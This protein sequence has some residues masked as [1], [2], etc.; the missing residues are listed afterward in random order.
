MRTPIRLRLQELEDRRTPTFGLGWGVPMA[1]AGSQSTNAVTTDL[2]NNSYVT[3]Y[4]N[5]TVDFDPG[6]GLA[7]FT[8]VVS[9]D[10]FV[11]KYSPTGTPVWV[12]TMGGAGSEGAFAVKLDSQNRVHLVGDFSGTADFDPGPATFALSSFGGS[13]DGF[14]ATLDNDGNFVWAGQL[15]GTGDDRA[16]GVG[17]DAADN[18]Y[19]VGSFSGTADLD[20]STSGGTSTVSSGGTDVYSVAIARIGSQSPA[21]TGSP[22]FVN[23]LGGT[24]DDSASAIAVEP[25]GTTFLAGDFQGTMDI[26]P[27]AGT[28]NLV[29]DGGSDAFSGRFNSAGNYVEAVRFGGTGTDR[30]TSLTRNPTTMSV[31]LAGYF[32]GSARYQY[33]VSSTTYSPSSPVTSA[34][35]I[36]GFLIPGIYTFGYVATY[37][38]PGND[39]LTSVATNDR[40]EIVV[41]GFFSGTA[42]LDPGPAKVNVTSAGGFDAFVG[43]YS[44]FAQYRWAKRFGGTGD[45]FASS[46]AFAKDGSLRIA[47]DYTG[48]TNP[49]P[50]GSPIAYSS[51]G[52][53][54]GFLY[55]FV[56]RPDLV[57]RASTGYWWMLAN[58]RT[59]FSSVRL[60]GWGG[61]GWKDVVRGDFNGD[62]RTDYAGRTPAGQW[63]ISNSLASGGYANVPAWKWNESLGW[64]NVTVADF[65]G[66]GIDDI[67]A[68]NKS[69]E[70]T[71]VH[72]NSYAT[73]YTVDMWAA[74]V[75]KDVKAV[76]L[77]GDKKPDL[78]ARN[79]AG[80]WWASINRFSTTFA[81]EHQYWGAWTESLKFNDISINDFNGDGQPDVV[82]RAANGQI[83][84]GTNDGTSFSFATSGTVSG[85]IRR[86]FYGDFTGDGKTDIAIL[87]A[88]NQFR[89]INLTSGFTPAAWGSWATGTTLDLQVADFD[90]DG[91]DDILGRNATGRWLLQ[92]S[93][94]TAFNTEI[95]S[96]TNPGPLNGL[97]GS[98]R[99]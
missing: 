41:G 74:G 6:P 72:G 29:S 60:N 7:A 87:D 99:R 66:D 31:A 39:F 11:A 2:R 88:A 1:G 63:W 92:R 3:G 70:L 5:G 19:V 21:L 79:A 10:I 38:G 50:T 82:G 40:N 68:L 58:N 77:N 75:W 13:Y 61:I 91:R 22:F 52:L 24:L 95:W 46:I 32:T 89:V 43:V 64:S 67:V 96:T 15:G 80:E 48:T 9:N 90:G 85:S 14:V 55:R 98:F 56:D 44:T 53:T 26:D 62:G 30:A 45:D 16:N 81:F 17:L 4:F 12:R 36:D 33:Y 51:A 73:S 57:G 18:V 86:T 54:D 23:K 84:I 59:A 65:N 93:S 27:G 37:G 49:D 97:R 69:N 25:D 42:D 20:A 8:S 94:G 28:V 35:G 71:F 83:W 78:L 76:D 34:G 47:G